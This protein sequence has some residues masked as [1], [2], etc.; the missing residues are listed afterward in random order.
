M[1]VY[2]SGNSNNKSLESISSDFN[3]SMNS[4]MDK[5]KIEAEYKL[6]RQFE[7]K[8]GED[9]EKWTNQQLAEYDKKLKK[10]LQSTFKLISNDFGKQLMDS[11]S[12]MVGKAMAATDAGVK[13]YLTAYSDYFSNIQTRLLGTTYNYDSLL[14]TLKDGLTGTRATSTLAVLNKLND[15]VSSGI[16][17]N[18]EQRAFLA[19]ISD[20]I[21]T[22]FDA[23]NGTLLQLI[24]L[25]QS[26]NTAAYLGIEAAIT[27]YLNSQFSDSSY[28]T[29]GLSKT[30]SSS[31][32][33][34]TSQLGAIGGAEFE[35]AAQ[36]WLGSFYSSGMNVETIQNLATALGYLG[37]GNVSSLLGNDKLN[38]LMAMASNYAGLDYSSLLTGGLSSGTV[39]QLLSGVYQQAYSMASSGDK[40]AQSQ[41]AS[42]FGM[43]ISDLTSILN[44]SS[45]DLVSISSNMLTYGQLLGKTEYELGRV[46]ARTSIQ[47]KIQNTISNIMAEIGSSISS[48]VGQ[49]LTYE[50]AD[51]VGTLNVPMPFIGQVDI[52][53]LAKTAILGYNVIGSLGEILSA[54]TAKGTLSLSNF[55]S[56]SSTGNGFITGVDSN[57]VSSGLSSAAYIGSGS[58][59][60]ILTGSL[61]ESSKQTQAI[62]S[63]V[64]SD[65][66]TLNDVDS[67]LLTIV[68]ILETALLTRDKTSYMGLVLE[69]LESAITSDGMIISGEWINKAREL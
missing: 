26:D 10:T 53:G 54:L 46:D 2:N 34:A 3:L 32:Y 58:A 62:S 9:K 22:T 5:L 28:L 63:G 43:T 18:I 38:N 52:A 57:I 60:D 35:Y 44:L 7:K 41:Y 29:S 21:A 4:R 47:D 20:K 1:A 40:V 6:K 37:S 23:A 56:T 42:L 14:S 19:T 8:F 49:Y 36:K 50:L 68:D 17:Y 45:Q 55:K 59:S 24:R 12:Q 30:V 64:A 69:K 33:E 61:A 16:S 39:N 51:L 13:K 66:K 31:L 67:S 65:S 27:E 15:L 25:N 11:T 48:N